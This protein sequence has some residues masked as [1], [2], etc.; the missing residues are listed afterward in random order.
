MHQWECLSLHTGRRAVEDWPH[1][2]LSV[3]PLLFIVQRP[4]RR[5]S[6]DWFIT[7][8]RPRLQTTIH[9]D[10]ETICSVALRKPFHHIFI[11]IFLSLIT[12]IVPVS[13]SRPFFSL[14]FACS[15]VLKSS[16]DRPDGACFSFLIPYRSADSEWSAHRQT[17]SIDHREKKTHTPSHT[18][19]VIY[20]SWREGS[21]KT[22]PLLS[23]RPKQSG[24]WQVIFFSSYKSF[25]FQSHFDEGRIPNFFAFYFTRHQ[26]LH[27][28]SAA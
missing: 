24:K 25:E 8:V 2:L 10:T 20:L 23:C 9:K 3:S 13:S 7:S 18:Q 5:K 19:T 15:F 6:P 17:D 21:L 14:T 11:Y 28:S 26:T 16:Q 1:C 22:S 12:D 27:S 4:L